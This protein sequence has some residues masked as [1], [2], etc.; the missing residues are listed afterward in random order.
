MS[1]T[2]SMPEERQL[3]RYLS[4]DGPSTFVSVGS[5]DCSQVIVDIPTIC[6]NFSDRSSDTQPRGIDTWLPWDGSVAL[7]AYEQP[8]LN[9]AAADR[10][11]RND[12]PGCQ[13]VTATPA[14]GAKPFL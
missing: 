11:V 2:G 12:S 5:R 9:E 8:L 3:R 13:Q 14:P 4:E 10:S 6:R 7:R 1:S